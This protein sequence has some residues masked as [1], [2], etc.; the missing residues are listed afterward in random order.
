[1]LVLFS[2]LLLSGCMQEELQLS[3]SFDDVDGLTPGSPVVYDSAEVG[4]VTE[5]EYTDQG[6][7]LVFIGI[8]QKFSELARSNSEFTIIENKN[9]PGKKAVEIIVSS[10]PGEQLTDGARVKGAS[11]LKAFT[12]RLKSDFGETLKSV[13]T[14]FDST[15]DK[16]SDDAV[17]TQLDSINTEL[18]QWK[19]EV[20][21]LSEST[22]TRLQNDVLPRMQE[23]V[24]HW[25]VKVENM[26]LE[27]TLEKV[28]EKI[29]D[30]ML[31]IE[32][33]MNK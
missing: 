29:N 7:F 21:T 27:E 8:K 12:S 1:M 11:K 28:E 33:E 17:Q 4:A 31:A 14:N 19:K 10:D 16:I 20:H 2:A 25:K 18:D 5:V 6:A 22:K 3:I 13:K 26:E 32:R 15:M 24:N 23:K 9:E 30:V